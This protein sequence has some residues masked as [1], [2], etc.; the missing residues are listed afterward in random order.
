MMK[1][2][3][4]IPYL[5]KIQKYVNH[6]TNLLRTADISIFSPE[7]IK[8]YC[9]KKYRYRV[10]FDTL[11]LII[12]NFFKFL[13]IVLINMVTIL[14]IPAKIATLD[15]LKI[16]VV[17][18]KGYDVITSVCDVAN[19]ILSRDSNYIADVVMWTKFGNSS[20][21]LTKVIITSTL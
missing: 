6:V 5:K 16:K 15:L 17:W 9:I 12:L 11:F 10:N 20:V 8:F 4:V 3:T 14:M 13:K 1:L 18:N 2:G 19:E 7:I 21:P